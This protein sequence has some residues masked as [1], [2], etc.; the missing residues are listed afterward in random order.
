[1]RKANQPMRTT[2]AG[3]LLLVIAGAVSA[4]NDDF[5]Y[6]RAVLSEAA[7]GSLI[8][9]LP[10]LEE[11]VGEDAVVLY[12]S[13]D[14]ILKPDGRISRRTHSLI[15]ILSEV[16]IDELG[17]PRIAFDAAHQEVV[18]HRC[19]TH[20]PDG[21]LVVATDHAFNQVTPNGVVHCTDDLVRQEMVITHVGIELGCVIDLDVEVRDLKAHAPWLEGL[22]FL[23]EDYPCVH[24]M[25]AIRHPAH[26]HLN[27]RLENGSAQELT[28][29]SGG[30]AAHTWRL[31]SLPGLCEHDDD[32]GGRLT[33]THL[34]YSTCPTWE[35]FQARVG[36]YLQ[37]ATTPDEAIRAHVARELRHGDPMT[38]AEQLSAVL[39][40]TSELRGT[41]TRTFEHFRRPRTAPCTFDQQ[42]GNEW[43]RLAL[44]L[45]LLDEIGIPAHPALRGGSPQMNRDVPALVQFD[46]LLLEVALD[47]E[48][49]FADPDR[50]EIRHPLR[51][52]RPV[53]VLIP[54]D[55][56]PTWRSPAE[57]GG[58]AEVEISAALGSDGSLSGS[59][60]LRLEG[61][62]FP[63]EDCRDLEGFL[64]RYAAR[65]IEGAKV[66]SNDLVSVTPQAG[67]LRFTF[68]ADTVAATAAGQR[69]FTLMGGPVSA[70]ARLE[71]YRLSRTA[72]TSPILL[73]GPVTEKVTWRMALPE[74]VHA[75]FLPPAAR[76]ET[77]VGSFVLTSDAEAVP[78]LPR[79]EA[80]PTSALTIAW[81]LELTA[82][83]IPPGRYGDL[84]RIVHTYNSRNQRLVVVGG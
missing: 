76:V 13:D 1:M 43:D 58:R 35:F 31:K 67:H 41:Q 22:L 68:R 19:Q 59:V 53:M 21:R 12:R 32:A 6:V 44:A 3:I 63:Y 70:I 60:T 33:R 82:D 30:L 37:A 28:S 14:I 48:T 27:A 47:G 36:E 34:I 40:F 64:D 25:V 57:S 79:A 62:L 9:A 50:G 52:E 20:T 26:L 42:C 55:A 77:P 23:Q 11:L 74:N 81:E 69:Y 72:R 71:R 7:A 75:Q 16:V 61:D 56:R 45:A 38:Q 8:A 24:R 78:T 18:I 83:T 29:S 17:D 2:V 46:A 65:L 39:D 49:L 15:L 73:G 66:E 51:F 10:P 5:G 54:G 80:P 84:K 4:Q